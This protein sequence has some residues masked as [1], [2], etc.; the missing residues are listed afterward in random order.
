[1]KLKFRVRSALVTG[2]VLAYPAFLFNGVAAHLLG[3]QFAIPGLYSVGLALALMAGILLATRLRAV[4]SMDVLFAAFMAWVFFRVALAYGLG[5]RSLGELAPYFVMLLW[6][7]GTY[8]LGRFTEFKDNSR[9]LVMLLVACVLL[10]LPL[11]DWTYLYIPYEVGADGAATIGYQGFGRS[12]F[13]ILLLALFTLDKPMTMVAVTVV[14][15][16]AL[17]VVGS[18]SEFYAFSTGCA[19]VISLLVFANRKALFVVAGGGVVAIAAGL[20]YWIMSGQ[21]LGNT[22]LRIMELFSG[23][24]TSLAERMALFFPILMPVVQNDLNFA[25][26]DILRYAD[27]TG[28]TGL[29]LHNILSVLTDFGLVG[30]MLYVS[31]CLFAAIELI[32]ATDGYQRLAA[33]G[34]AIAC[35]IMV[36]GAKSLFW[37][38][39]ALFWGLGAHCRAVRR[40]QAAA[41]GAVG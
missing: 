35:I 13:L 21:S 24:S 25:F 15:A 11:V 19:V 4:N 23:E 5:H 7:G 30:L 32:R 36:L 27:V 28:N 10:L 2:F 1:M 31:L 37:A 22:T 17:G 40:W 16:G 38:E 6:Y 3:G 12:I 9:F 18:R 20:A 29:Y 39:I 33:I 34:F 41:D 8:S 14:G 26:G